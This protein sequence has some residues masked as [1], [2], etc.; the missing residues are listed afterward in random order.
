MPGDD[1]AVFLSSEF[2]FLLKNVF[3]FLV[4][5]S[6]FSTEGI[7]ACLE[8]QQSHLLVELCL[9]QVELLIDAV[10]LFRVLPF[11]PR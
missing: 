4:M 1:D 7:L 8:L 2:L 9:F 10:A 3:V 6:Y 11:S 5:S